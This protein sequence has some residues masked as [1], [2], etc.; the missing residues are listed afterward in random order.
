M[1]KRRTKTAASRGRKTFP[2]KNRAKSRFPSYNSP[3]PPQSFPVEFDY[4]A[5]SVFDPLFPLDSQTAKRRGRPSRVILSEV[6]NRSM[7][8]RHTLGHC[9]VWAQVR[10]KLMGAQTTEDITEAFRPVIHY[11]QKFLR[12]P[13][14]L[15][16]AI[17]HRDFPKRNFESQIAFIADSLAADGRVT[18][19]RSREICRAELAKAGRDPDE[20][21]PSWQER[22]ADIAR[23]RR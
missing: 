18:A 22:Q 8:F 13:A 16:E 21:L 15:L 3:P 6:L 1:H 9:G 4:D 20:W 12:E 11:G 17:K 14:T 10:E 19:R 2:L 23:R 5:E 7:D